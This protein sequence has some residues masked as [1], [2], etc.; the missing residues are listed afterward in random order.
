M[1][2]IG[3]AAADAS[4]QTDESKRR[5]R[6]A[7]RESEERKEPEEQKG[8]QEEYQN[9]S[10]ELNRDEIS[11]PPSD[12][13]PETLE[14]LMKA[15]GRLVISTDGAKK[16]EPNGTADNFPSGRMKASTVLMQFLSCGAISFKDCRPTFEKDQGLSL[17]GHYKARLPRGVGNQIGTS[18]EN[19]SFSRLK[20][21][22]QEYFSGSIIE[23]KKENIPTL[24]K[25]SSYNAD[26]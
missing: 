2:S 6:R 21:E 8:E 3:K 16:E 15:G 13:S 9:Q 18:M 12:S 14:S 7:L 11:P 23:T 26:R 17:F 19:S 20:L 24:K 1:D 25:S 4:T 22:D 10:T 5:R